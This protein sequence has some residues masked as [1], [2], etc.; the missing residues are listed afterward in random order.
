MTRNKKKTPIVKP[1][2]RTNVSAKA[3]L[4][5]QRQVPKDTNMGE[6]Y[7]Q[8]TPGITSTSVSAIP[9]TSSQS[10]LPPDKSDAILSYLQCIDES[11]KALV[12]RVS[13][14]E[15]HRS[16]TSTPKLPRSHSHVS[17]P[18]EGA[19]QLNHAIPRPTTH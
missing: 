18:V 13:E 1:Q 12:R 14:L 9:S 5:R 15:S 19:S 3:C 2:K 17:V 6:S 7:T 11:N 10:D 8:P 16:F 4:E